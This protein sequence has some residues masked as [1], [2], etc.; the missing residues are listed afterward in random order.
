MKKISILVGSH[1]VAGVI[2][3]A[4]GIY[5]LPLFTADAE[6]SDADVRAVSNTARYTGEFKRDLPGSDPLHWAQGKIAITDDAIAFEGEVAPGPDYKIYLIPNF[7]DTKEKF[8]AAKLHAV[9]IGDL[10]TFGNFVTPLPRN[11]GIDQFTTVV[12]WCERFSQFISA[13]QYR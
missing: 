3:F 2:G 6:A 1:L 5:T 12:I 4:V 10:N 11:I 7:V 8:L 13:A 9:R